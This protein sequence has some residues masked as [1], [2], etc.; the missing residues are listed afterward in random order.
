MKLKNNLFIGLIFIQI[1]NLFAQ[2]HD[3]WANNVGWDQ[4]TH[5]KYYIDIKPA[6]MGPNAF[7]YASGFTGILDT[8]YTLEVKANSYFTKGE[9]TLNPYLSVNIPFGKFAS[10]Q[11]SG[12]PVEYFNTSH[13]LKTERKIFWIGYYDK[14][15]AGDLNVLFT[16][17]IKSKPAMAIQVGLKTATGGRLDLARFTDSPQY[18]FNY[19]ISFGNK[20]TMVHAV[21]GFT[22]WQTFDGDHPQD[23]AYIFDFS[24]DQHLGKAWYLKPELYGFIAYLKHGDRPIIGKV[25]LFRKMEHGRFMIEFVKGIVDFPYYGINLGISRSWR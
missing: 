17:K 22:A 24:L 2:T 20:N 8:Q 21:S 5:Y 10:L 19:A 4:K 25:S 3:W 13:E 7:Y 16:G 15:A 11:V 14:W 9:I 23:D 1:S 18:F 6:R 12:V